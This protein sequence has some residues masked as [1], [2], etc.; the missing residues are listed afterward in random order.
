VFHPQAKKS[1]RACL[2]RRTTGNQR[3]LKLD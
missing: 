3:V 1:N 2:E